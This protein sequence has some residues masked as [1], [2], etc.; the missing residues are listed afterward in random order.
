MSNATKPDHN[1]VDLDRVEREFCAVYGTNSIEATLIVQHNF[2]AVLA[3]LREHRQRE[4]CSQA[5]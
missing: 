1:R 3:E 5:A 4:R 2:A